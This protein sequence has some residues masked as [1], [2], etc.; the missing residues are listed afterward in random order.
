MPCA[1]PFPGQSGKPRPAA[2]NRRR[3]G[4]ISGNW[5]PCT[6]RHPRTALLHPHR[7]TTATAIGGTPLAARSSRVRYGYRPGL[8]L[9][10]VPV[11]DMGRKPIACSYGQPACIQ[12]DANSDCGAQ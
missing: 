9:P 10:F 8:L 12:L 5:E 6:G 1:T 7:Q 2:G 4:A 3:S 11:L